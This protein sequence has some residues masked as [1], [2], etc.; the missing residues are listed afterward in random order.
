MK[1]TNE[2][3]GARNEKKQTLVHRAKEPPP[4][5]SPEFEGLV[6]EHMNVLYAVAVRL[7]RNDADAADLVQNTVVKALRF[8][9][10]FKKGTHIKAWLLTILRNTFIND[11]R[12]KARRPIHVALSGTEPATAAYSPDP[13]VRSTTGKP[14]SSE[15]LELVN[16]EVKGAVDS[17]PKDF[18]AAV[19][20]ADLEG[21]SYKE[22]A[23]AL[24]CPL[25]TVMSRIYRGR[26]LLRERLQDYVRHR[27]LEGCG[28]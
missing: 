8:H 4:E 11:Y 16:D 1:K 19:L 9:A 23:E 2:S 14:T 13:V 6:L 15:L 28:V 24:D 20:M 25:G 3:T 21:R 7:T 12:Q 17:L 10:R 22:I 18:R 5:R 27:R 26:R